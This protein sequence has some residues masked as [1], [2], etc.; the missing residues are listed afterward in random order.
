MDE[1]TREQIALLSA[2]QLATRETVA[3]LLAYEALR[4]DDPKGLL[5]HFSEAADYS[6]DKNAAGLPIGPAMMKAQEAS[7]SEMDWMVAAALVIIDRA[8]GG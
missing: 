6:I 7:R 3:R 1:E 2:R 8:A 4:H 5:Q